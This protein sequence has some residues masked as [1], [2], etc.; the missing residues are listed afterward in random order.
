MSLDS[1]NTNNIKESNDMNNNQKIIM[2]NMIKENEIISKVI[3][4]KLDINYALN[5]LL[6]ILNEQRNYIENISE[7]HMM[8]EKSVTRLNTS[9]DILKTKLNFEKKED[10]DMNKIINANK[11]Q[12]KPNEVISFSKLNNNKIMNQTFNK[13]L[14]VPSKKGSVSSSSRRY[15]SDTSSTNTYSGSSNIDFDKLIQMSVSDFNKK[16][17]LKP[18]NKKK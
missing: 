13:K 16:K 4:G 18:I 10:L 3:K 9:I 5:E 11:V 14:K 7:E 8:L 15:I 17:K 1:K 12:F 6:K 2:K